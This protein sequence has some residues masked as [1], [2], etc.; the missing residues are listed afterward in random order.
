[1]S[2]AS[3]KPNTYIFKEGGIGNYFYLL[4]KG[5]MEVISKNNQKR[6]LIL[7]ESFGDLNGETR[8]TS[9]K[10]I[11]ECLLWVMERKIFRKIVENITQKNFEQ[12]KNFIVSILILV[13]IDH[14]KKHFYVLLFIKKDSK[15]DNSLLEK[16]ILLIVYI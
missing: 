13:N 8:V 6:I 2:L 9:T 4:N 5:T 12:S 1:M 14:H 15:E 11:T 7:G 3:I 16:V 10:A